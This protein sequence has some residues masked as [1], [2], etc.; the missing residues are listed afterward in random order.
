MSEAYSSAS[1][2]PKTTPTGIYQQLSLVTVISLPMVN[3]NQL[4]N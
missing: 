1:R 2:E 4:K 3:Y